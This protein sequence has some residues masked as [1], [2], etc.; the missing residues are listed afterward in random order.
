MP[1]GLVCTVV[2]MRDAK[3]ADA[4]EGVYRGRRADVRKS[5]TIDFR[6]R[7]IEDGMDQKSIQDVKAIV[8]GAFYFEEVTV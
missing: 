6:K 3:L 4:L 1:K 7:M 8:E 5:F 2:L